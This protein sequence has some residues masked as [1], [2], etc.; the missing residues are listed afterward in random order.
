MVGLIIRNE[1]LV[2]AYLKNVHKVLKENFSDYEIILVNNKTYTDFRPIVKDLDQDIKKD[3]SV[4]NLSNEVVED[5]ALFSGLDRANGD[6]TVFLDM[7]FYKHPELIVKLYNATQEKNKDIVYLKNKQRQLSARDKFFFGI[8]YKLLHSVFDKNVS[9][10]M[11]KSRIISRRALNSLLSLRESIRYF[12]GL[13]SYVGYESLALEVDVPRPPKHFKFK[14][15]IS[16]ALETYIS[17]TDILN[18]A[19]LWIFVISLLFTLT[20]IVDVIVFNVSNKV[21]LGIIKHDSL[22]GWSFLIVFISIIF[23][24]FCLFFY[25]ISLMVNHI[26][27]EAKQRPIYIIESIQRL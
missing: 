14:E 20:V 24:L 4:I 23:S 16:F 12:K 9:S 3:V 26:K 8:F 27:K 22:P 10:K 15:L 2:N 21:F 25:F 7:H 1:E 17:F 5:N 11:E 13:F 19:F 18:K 6:Y